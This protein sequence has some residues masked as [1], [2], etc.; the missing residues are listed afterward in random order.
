MSLV[1]YDESSSEESDVPQKPL[2]KPKK[3]IRKKKTKPSKLLPSLNDLLSGK[4][5]TAASL[6]DFVSEKQRSARLKEVSELRDRKILHAKDY[7]RREA[8]TRALE[9][10][11]KWRAE[12]RAKRQ[13]NEHG[14]LIS[15]AGKV[16]SS[17]GDSKQS[18]ELLGTS[19]DSKND[20]RKTIKERE[21]AKRMKG[22]SSHA[23]WK[24][25]AEMQLRQEFD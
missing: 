14:R 24:T 11:E 20:D 8:E 23:T 19:V 13:L 10:D 12:W 15:A 18:E 6:P 4:S 17:T 3:L 2:P 25:E 21:H 1:G 22:Q 7:R 16:T 9:K 5:S